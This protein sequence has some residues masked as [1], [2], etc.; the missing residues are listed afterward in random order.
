MSVFHRNSA[1]D[2]RASLES[3]K[4]TAEAANVK[5]NGRKTMVR[6][7]IS[8][9]ALL[10][11]YPTATLSEGGRESSP[12]KSLPELGTYLSK[13][14]EGWRER[15]RQIVKQC[16]SRSAH[17][18]PVLLLSYFPTLDSPTDPRL[19]PDLTGLDTPLADIRVH[20]AQTTHHLRWALELGSAY[21]GM[22]NRRAHCSIEYDIVKQAEYL[23]PL[24]VSVFE[25]PWN[26][27]MFRPDYIQILERED[28][29]H[30]V[31]EHGVKEVW[32]WGYHHGNIEPAES[33][34][35]GPHGDI[36]NSE[37]APDLPVCGRTY[38][39][40]NYNYSR[41]LGEALENH[42]HQ[43]EAVLGHVDGHGLFADFVDPYGQPSPAVNSC[44]NVHFPP[45]G[46][47]DYDWRNT[48]VVESDCLHWNPQ[49]TGQ[50]ASVSCADWTCN[51]DGGETYKVWW[52]M[53]FPGRDNRLV[54]NG[55]RLRN[56]WDS[57]ANFDAVVGSGKGLLR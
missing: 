19:D 7:I 51:D 39:V 38:T 30:L 45:N 27:G 33:N 44:G 28:V 35:A 16:E 22:S 48:T 2:K 56:W 10:L 21:H 49:G 9:I 12:E 15:A 54:L 37:R 32:L 55:N 47:A 14:P 31:D 57:I 24:P 3:F 1:S 26:P 11:M 13:L 52:M 18:I 46:I 42:G 25:V 29:C 5:E 6:F 20:V 41:G 4:A 43:F 50:P 8:I 36:S 17:R 40:Y 34:M 53:N 23:E